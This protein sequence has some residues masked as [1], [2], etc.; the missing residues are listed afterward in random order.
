[1]L[2]STLNFS[3]IVKFLNEFCISAGS[4]HLVTNHDY[5]PQ[6]SR[7]FVHLLSSSYPCHVFNCSGVRSSKSLQCYKNLEYY[8]LDCAEKHVGAL[9]DSSQYA[10][11]YMT[12]PS[13]LSATSQ[14]V[15]LPEV[16]VMLSFGC[17]HPH[18]PS[19]HYRHIRLS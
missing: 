18:S 10:Q 16:T 4:L 7:A 3:N 5:D 1:M 15:R 8:R 2:C 6:C 12:V 13:T 11:H 14:R 17:H 9:Y 19:H